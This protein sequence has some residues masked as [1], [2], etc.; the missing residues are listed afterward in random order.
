EP[1]KSAQVSSPFAVTSCRSLPFS[2]S[3]LVSTKG[4][5]KRNGNGAS[6]TVQVAQKA[7]EADIKSVRVELPKKL[8]S[9]LTT[10]QKACPEA[11][12]DANP[13][14]CPA[15]SVVGSAVAHTPVL[16]VPLTGPAYFVSHG[17]ARFPELVVVLQG[18]DVTIYLAG[19]THIDSK[20]GITRS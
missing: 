20:T 4:K 5:A 7:G 1:D 2:P 17:G 12:F 18:D 9:R 3:F 19:E 16:P 10:L 11:A 6:L 8:P 14:S 15:G 13:A